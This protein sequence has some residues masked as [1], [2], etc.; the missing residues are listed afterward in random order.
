MWQFIPGVSK[1]QEKTKQSEAVKRKYYQ[2]YDKSKRARNFNES[3][4]QNRPWLKDTEEGLVCTYCTEFAEIRTLEFITGCKSYKSDSIK[5]HEDSKQHDRSLAKFKAQQLP[6]SQSAASKIVRKLNSSII[7]KL[8]KM[9]R[10]CH[11][12]VMNNRPFSD[13]LWM[14]DLDEAKGLELLSTYRTTKYCQNFVK[15]IADVEFFQVKEQVKQAKFLCVIGDGSTDSGVKEQEMWFGRSS[16]AGV[17]RVNFIGVHSPERANAENIVSGLKEIVGKNLELEWPYFS[18]K[19]AALACDGASVMVGARAGVG[20]LL[21]RDSPTMIT[22]HCMAHRLELCLKDS[23]KKLNLYEK[24]ISVLAM[25]IYY[26]YHNSA[27]NRSMLVRSFKALNEDSKRKLLMPT[28]VGGT[29]WIGHT[30]RALTNLTR[31]YQFIVTHL[32]QVLFRKGGYLE[33][34][35]LLHHRKTCHRYTL[36]SC[37]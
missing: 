22:I 5:K 28:R 33:P 8:T 35:L 19:L 15:A 14:C 6:K 32:G 16:N 2:E 4:T 30:F 36:G 37:F 18:G 13:F 7:H 20:T 23:V 3:W 11:A 21:N 26:F 29:R 9:F 10:N 17:I 24:C 25:G 1:P 27:L 31:S 34:I 12:L